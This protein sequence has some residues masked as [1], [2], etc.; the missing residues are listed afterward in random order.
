[1]TLVDCAARR[2]DGEIPGAARVSSAENFVGKF[3][4][5]VLNAVGRSRRS[6]PGAGFVPLT[7][8]GSVVQAE[9]FTAGPPVRSDRIDAGENTAL[10]VS[11]AESFRGIRAETDTAEET[12]CNPFTIILDVSGTRRFGDVRAEI[13]AA[14]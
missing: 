4:T 3:D 6:V 2:R 5:V 11:I 9:L 13:A 14:D 12:I 8:D 7:I 10:G 1:M